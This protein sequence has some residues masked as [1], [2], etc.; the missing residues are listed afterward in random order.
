MEDRIHEASRN[1]LSIAINTSL[2]KMTHAIPKDECD[3]LSIGRYRSVDIVSQAG[4]H[5]SIATF[6]NARLFLPPMAKV[7]FMGVQVDAL[8]MDETIQECKRMIE[9]GKPHQHVVVNTAKI[10][11]MQTNK[12]LYD[13]VVNADL[14]NADGV[15]IV[16]GARLLGKRLPERVAGCDLFYRLI[17]LSAKEGYRVYFLGAKQE[18]LDRMIENFKEEFP[19]LRVAGSRNGY[20]DDRKDS[21]RIATGIRKSK[22]QLLFVGISSPK[23]ERFIHSY[24]KKTGVSFA[25]GVGGSFDIYAG[26]TKR[27]PKWVQNIGFEWLYRLMQEPGRMFG[28]YWKTNTRFT[29]LI[30]KAMRRRYL[31]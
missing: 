11:N 23:K 17:E 28:R 25:M 26:H 19:K 8:T 2:T 16:W 3:L 13:D 5:F 31:G 20:Y 14:I 24:L 7:D 1:F 29:L 15:G 21:A 22:A 9:S 10:V 30:L 12:E 18:I 4:S 27:A 6:I